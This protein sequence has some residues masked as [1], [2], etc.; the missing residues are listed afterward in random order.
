MKRPTLQGFAAL[1]AT[2]RGA[3]WM[4]LSA[5]LFSLA[6]AT[7]RHLARDMHFIEIAFFRSLFGLMVF[8][9]WFWRRG[10]AAFRTRRTPLYLARGVTSVSA[11]FLWFGALAL[12]PIADAT[13]ISF[14]QPLFVTVAAVIVLSEPMRTSRWIG[15]LVGFA[16]TLIVLRPGFGDFNLG[17]LMVLGAAVFIAASAI[18]V[19]IVGRDDPPEMIAMYQV[20]YMLPL[21]FFPALFVWTWPGAEQ[22]FW[23]AMVG[24]L[25][26]F[27]QIALTRAYVAGDATAV[28]P[29][30]FTRLIF[31]T[32]LGFVL[33]A[34]LPD[35]PTVLGGM[36]IFASSM[37]VVHGEARARRR[38]K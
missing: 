24:V 14:A 38:P 27:A 23:A 25:S 11:M 8:A 20:L 10:F 36:V 18:L 3:A 13:A 6:T 5:A 37:I 2:A 31:A 32:A 34:E 19:K 4:V 28:T 21:T 16:G 22:L 29:F 26:T 30:D 9:P 15:L 7:V 1:P 17:A 35:L 12:I 33:F